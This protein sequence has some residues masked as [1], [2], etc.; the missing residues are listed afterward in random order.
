MNEK[1][2]ITQFCETLQKRSFDDCDVIENLNLMSNF[3]SFQHGMIYEIDQFNIF[4]LKEH[5]DSFNADLPKQLHLNIINTHFFNSYENERLCIF[6]AQSVATTYFKT[7]YLLFYPICDK[8]NKILGFVA[9]SFSERDCIQHENTLKTELMLLSQLLKDRL[10]ENKVSFAIKSLEDILD[11]TGIDIY[12]NDFN[13]H[14]ILYVNKSMAAPYGGAKEFMNRKCWDVLFPGQNGQCEFCPQKN[15]IDDEGNP[16]KVYTWDYQRAMDGSWFRVFSS[17]FNWIDGRLAHVV[18]SADITDNKNY[19][20]LVHHMANFDELTNL[21][22][23]RKLLEDCEQKILHA[24]E[25]EQGYVLFFDIDGFKSINDNYGHDAGDEFLVKLA[26][27]FT[28][29]PLLKNSIYRNGGDEFIAVIGGEHITKEHIKNLANTII[30]RF[31]KSW[32]LTK[33]EVYCSTSI[34]IACFPDDGQNSDELIHLADQAMYNAK[35]A[36]GAS[37]CFCYQLKNS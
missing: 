34:G 30:Y 32:V 5:T 35:K 8:A 14:D 9:F 6:D 4:H 23:R 15:L 17:A 28:N 1:P 2:L 22:N 13:N 16:T 29:I 11:N 33:G 19:E 18:S 3:Y 7:P 37:F 24:S 25:T 31:R 21:P 10:Y 12:V 27:F 36:G 26:E 20:A